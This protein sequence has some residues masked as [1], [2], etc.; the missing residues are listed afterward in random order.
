MKPASAAARLLAVGV[1]LIFGWRAY[2]G[3]AE[4][5]RFRQGLRLDFEKKEA[6]AAA[7]LARAAVGGERLDILVKVV[8][9]RLEQFDR[10]ADATDWTQTD[11]AILSA[12]AVSELTHLCRSPAS[13]RPWSGLGRIYSRLEMVRARERLGQGSEEYPQY[14]GWADLG[15][16]GRL[17]I[18]AYRRAIEGAPNWYSNY[19]RL[20]IAFGSWGLID[21]A[22]ETVERSAHVMPLVWKHRW[23]GGDQTIPDEVLEAFSRGA[24]D[25]LGHVPFLT[26]TDHLIALGRLEILR[27]DH[28]RAREALERALAATSGADALNSAD[29]AYLLGRTYEALD[30]PDRAIEWLERSAKHPSM[31]A[32]ALVALGEIARKRGDL[33][34]ALSR[35]QS[36]RWLEPENVDICIAY[37]RVA[38]AMGNF[39][40]AIEALK[41]A[42]VSSPRDL[43]PQ[44][45]LVET[46]IDSGDLGAASSLLRLIAQEEKSPDEVAQLTKRVEGLLGDRSAAVIGASSSAQ[47][48]GTLP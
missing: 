1:A 41:W 28:A 35:L 6:A 5:A 14:D 4:F 39:P 43:R 48:S 19:D 44:L 45:E 38:R 18:A 21:D 13:W 20:A 12:A 17:A 40:A 24:W 7:L 26:R 10:L 15:R 36:A 22:L 31:R 33:A 37:A 46:H 27:G 42:A 8:D 34:T 23:E 9:V 25:A 3:F 16:N 32:S 30:D 2:Q 29:A 11:P 47:F